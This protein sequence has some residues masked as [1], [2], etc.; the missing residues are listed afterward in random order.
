M[1]HPELPIALTTEF[2]ATFYASMVCSQRSRPDVPISPSTF[3]EGILRGFAGACDKQFH[4][5][6]DCA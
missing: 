4:I 2:R 3:F 1:G 5:D 6:R